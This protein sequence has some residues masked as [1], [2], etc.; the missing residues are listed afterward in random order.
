M[1]KLSSNINNIPS[2]L[3]RHY[4]RGQTILSFEQ[5]LI[6]GTDEIKKKVFVKTITIIVKA[7]L[8]KLYCPLIKRL[9]LSKSATLF[10][11]SNSFKREKG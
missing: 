2:P 3:E 10:F 7:I 1:L 6:E 9:F 8:V 4:C 11:S 5:N